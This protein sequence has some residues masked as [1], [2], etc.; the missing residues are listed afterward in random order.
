MADLFLDYD[1]IAA[2]Y[3]Q[4][5]PSQRPTRRGLALLGLAQHVKAGN[6]LE[7]GS[8]TG[9]WLNLLFQV[10]KG[11]YGLDYSAGMITQ[12]RNQPAPL[13]L[14]RGTALHLPYRG[15][16]FE[17]VYSVDAIHHFGDPQA[18]I[19]E[20]FR[21]L[22]PGGALAIIGFD[23]HAE[24]THWYI[25]DYFDGIHETDL[26]RYPS[27]EAVRNWMQAE[28]FE[29]VSSQIAEHVLNKQ[30][31]EAVL[32]DPFLKHNSTSQLALLSVDAYQRTSSQ[33]FQKP[34]SA[35]NKSPFAQT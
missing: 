20:A 23:P 17:L 26:R 18:F 6:I 13:N 25:Y 22:K 5:Y 3:N 8:G 9:F 14:T 33:R 1:Q 30:V 15:H 27:S 35:M 7:V 10:S 24:T 19:R 28:G 2:E 34:G 16:S 21:V 12:A 29:D 31:G 32:Q 11:L 4:R